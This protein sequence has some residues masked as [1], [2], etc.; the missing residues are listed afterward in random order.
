MQNDPA[1]YSAFFSTAGQ[2]RDEAITI[3]AKS[4]DLNWV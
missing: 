4:Q 3:L 2:D 1:H